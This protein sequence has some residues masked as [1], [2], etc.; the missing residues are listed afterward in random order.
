MLKVHRFEVNWV[1][2]MIF[3][4]PTTGLDLDSISKFIQNLQSKVEISI[5]SSYNGTGRK[6]D[7]LD[8]KGVTLNVIYINGYY[9]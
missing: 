1:N 9:K 7:G 3:Q 5:I 4:N 2:F 6:P 8:S